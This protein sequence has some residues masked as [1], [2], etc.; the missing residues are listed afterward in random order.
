MGIGAMYWFH[1]WTDCC[2]SYQ[3]RTPP[4]VSMGEYKVG[5]FYTAHKLLNTKVLYTVESLLT[6]A[7]VS[8]QF[9]LRTAFQ[10]PVFPTIQTLY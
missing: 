8:G 9:Y 7:P 5:S 2:Y 3:K 4:K 1:Y 6:D 10:N